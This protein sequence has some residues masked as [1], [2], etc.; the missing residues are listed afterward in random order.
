MDIIHSL[1]SWQWII[2][3]AC[4]LMVGLSKTGLPGLGILF[5]PLFAMVLPAR[6]STGAMLPLLIVG[7]IFAVSWYRRHAVWRHL[8]KL[9]PWAFAGIV[10]GFF[11]MGALND[12][13][14]RPLIGAIVIVLLGISFW[15]D[16][17]KKGQSPVPTAWWFAAL[18]GLIAGMT[19]M[20]AN[21]GGPVMMVFLLAMRLPKDEFLGTSAWFFAIVNLIKV[22]F[23]AGLGLITPSTLLL[24]ACLAAGVIAGS[25]IGVWTARKLPERAFSVVV[26]VMALGSAVLLFF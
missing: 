25:L 10:I 13:L 26:Q 21:A 12:R 1:A 4:A 14:L 7:D 3:V 5:V 22:P 20:L 19:T 8:V 15:R 24:D 11:A 18:L 9:L 6:L 2:G 17:V 16:T 23:S